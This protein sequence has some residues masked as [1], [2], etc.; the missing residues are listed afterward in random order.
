MTPATMSAAPAIRH[1]PESSR[2]R[3]DPN[4][5]PTS[6]DSSRAGATWLTPKAER[7]FMFADK[8]AGIVK[9]EHYSALKNSKT[10]VLKNE[11]H[12]VFGD[13]TVVIKSTPGPTPGHQSLF[14]K[15]SRTGGVLLTG[16][17][18]HYAAER[19][20]KKMPNNDKKEQTEGSRAAIE[21]FLVKTGAQLWIQHDIVEN[22]GGK[23]IA[24]CTTVDGG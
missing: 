14:I 24:A 20:L 9:P 6:V 19:T 10:I 1:G 21:A 12:D 13:G 3:R 7:D 16:D 17:L 15:L 11:D 22:A 23:E 2:N 5:A 4:Q 18:Y 8:P